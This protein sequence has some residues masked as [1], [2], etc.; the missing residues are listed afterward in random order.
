MPTMLHVEATKSRIQ[1]KLNTVDGGSPGLSF[2]Q[3]PA[4]GEYKLYFSSARELL[5]QI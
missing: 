4:G 5:S 1:L 2:T 3:C